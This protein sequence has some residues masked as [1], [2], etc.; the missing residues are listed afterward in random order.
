MGETAADIIETSIRLLVGSGLVSW[1]AAVVLVLVIAA[2]AVLAPKAGRVIGAAR[3]SPQ[4]VSD[5][6][7]PQPPGVT[8]PADPAP[9]ATE[10]GRGSG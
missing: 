4:T 5:E 1:P 6:S 8:F 7:G 2:L 3:P 9:D 10:P